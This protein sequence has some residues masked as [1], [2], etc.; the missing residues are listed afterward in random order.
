MKPTTLATIKTAFA[1]DDTI[2][3]EQAEIILKKLYDTEPRRKPRNT[4]TSSP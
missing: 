3:L 4:E 2:T 1:S